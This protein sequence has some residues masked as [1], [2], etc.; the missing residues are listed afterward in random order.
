MAPFRV[1]PSGIPEG[2]TLGG[3][4]IAQWGWAMPLPNRIRRRTRVR[5]LRADERGATLVE[6][7]LVLPLFLT[8][9]FGI[10]EFSYALAQHNELRHVVR[11][12]S[13]VAS[14]DAAADVQSLIC[15]GF[16]LI[17][18]A[19]ATY[20]VTGVSPAPGGPG[21]LAEVRTQVTYRTLTGFFDAMFAGTTLDSAHNFYVEQSTMDD[22][23]TWPTGGVTPCP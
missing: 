6:M 21:G 18:T 13:R 14:V 23:P 20:Q 5:S 9:V 11:E 7:A 15:D 22:G 4:S 10:I 8:L 3:A 19:D 1:Y 2:G 16:A 17:N 12:A